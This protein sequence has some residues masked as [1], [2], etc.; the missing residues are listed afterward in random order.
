MWT[1]RQDAC[2]AIS[3]DAKDSGGLSRL[4]VLV[5]DLDGGELQYLGFGGSY[6]VNV[7][8][9]EADDPEKNLASRG[10]YQ[11]VRSDNALGLLL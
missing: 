2:K 10:I 6:R 5:F 8:G 4:Q 7:Q 1:S 9:L 11:V 3:V